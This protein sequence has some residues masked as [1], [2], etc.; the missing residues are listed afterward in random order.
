[1]ART[2]FLQP[3]RHTSYFPFYPFAKCRDIALAALN[4]EAICHKIP[5]KYFPLQSL[6]DVIVDILCFWE[7][8]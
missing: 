5:I 6:R 2:D 1:M 3:T 8:K 7:V 4:S